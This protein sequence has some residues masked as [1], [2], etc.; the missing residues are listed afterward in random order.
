M[1][2]SIVVKV[3]VY[4]LEE[5]LGLPPDPN[6]FVLSIKSKPNGMWAPV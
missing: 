3:F 2:V 6:S 4:V 5:P 1:I